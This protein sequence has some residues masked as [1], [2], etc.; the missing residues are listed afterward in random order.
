[1][2]GRQLERTRLAWRRTVLAGAVVATLAVRAAITTLTPPLAA[3]V[4]GVAGVGWL[5]YAAL[6]QRRAARLREPARREPLAAVALVLLY[7]LLG[8]LLVLRPGS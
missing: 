5:G 3:L 6:A 8:G 2:N 1:V 4:V 7:V